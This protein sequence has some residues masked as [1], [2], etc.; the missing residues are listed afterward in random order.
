[1]ECVWYVLSNTELEVNTGGDAQYTSINII[2][3]YLYKILYIN[4]L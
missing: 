4:I 2:Q 1:M 3:L